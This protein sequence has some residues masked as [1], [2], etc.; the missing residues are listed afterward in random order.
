M[1]VKNLF[2]DIKKK[3]RNIKLIKNG[4]AIINQYIEWKLLAKIKSKPSCLILRCWD[5]LKTTHI[6]NVT[7]KRIMLDQS[8]INCQ[9]SALIF[10]VDE[11]KDFHQSKK[12][13][14]KFFFQ[15]KYLLLFNLQKWFFIHKNM[16][17]YGH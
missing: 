2:G 16:H 8:T 12:K 13:E 11:I 14:H 7:S 3:K 1:L 4:I 6:K 5:I 15:W 9:A 17:L 10:M